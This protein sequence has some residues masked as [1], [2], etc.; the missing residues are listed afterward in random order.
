MIAKKFLYVSLIGGLLSAC[1]PSHELEDTKQ[2]LSSVNKKLTLAESQLTEEK[3]KNRE[4]S[5]E[6]RNLHDL[7]STDIEMQ[8]ISLKLL[9]KEF[10]T[11]DAQGESLPLL[12]SLVIAEHLSPQFAYIK[13][14]DIKDSDS[15]VSKYLGNIDGLDAGQYFL[16][17]IL[18]NDAEIPFQIRSNDPQPI[19]TNDILFIIEPE[20]K[21]PTL[22]FK[23]AANLYEK[24]EYDPRGMPPYDP[25]TRIDRLIEHYQLNSQE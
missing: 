17:I 19:K 4:Q 11:N 23:T 13:T 6:F 3:N 5:E 8:A 24:Y 12:H 20:K 21:V 9:A 1:T 10:A 7:S 22:Y 2:E 15:E 18:S 16:H 14:A 25:E